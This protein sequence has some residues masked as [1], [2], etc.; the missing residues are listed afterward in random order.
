[1]NEGA[2]VVNSSTVP[3]QTTDSPLL[4]V[5]ENHDSHHEPNLTPQI[6]NGTNKEV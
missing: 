3:D 5:D 1:M 2:V 6:V 4:D